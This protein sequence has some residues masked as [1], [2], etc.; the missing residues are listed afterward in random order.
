MLFYCRNDRVPTSIEALARGVAVAG[1]VARITRTGAFVDFGSEAQGLVTPDHYPAEPL[2]T[3]QQVAARVGYVDARRGR[4]RLSLRPTTDTFEEGSNVTGKVVSTVPD[5]GVFVDIGTT[6]DAL[7]PTRSLPPTD[8]VT[9][10]Q[11][12]TTWITTIDTSRQRVMLSMR[13]PF[14]QVPRG[15][16]ITGTVRQVTDQYIYVDIGASINGR[17]PTT[18]ET[19][20]PHATQVGQRLPVE[21]AEV[22]TKG[23]TITLRRQPPTA[24]ASRPTAAPPP[25]PPAHANAPPPTAPPTTDASSPAD[26]RPAPDELNASAPRKIARLMATTPP[27]LPQPDPSPVATPA[28]CLDQASG[29]RAGPD[30][31][32]HTT[33]PTDTEAPATAIAPTVTQETPTTDDPDP[34]TLPPLRPPRTRPAL[35]TS[36]PLPPPTATTIPP[37]LLLPAP[38]PRMTPPT[39]F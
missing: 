14:A 17:L 22:D 11:L 35:P 38:R 33:P 4:V 28:G 3:G 37:T 36:L 21:V 23:R 9:P 12:V 34:E 32:A 24:T 26:G 10:G 15:A 39:P 7:V 27:L 13:R 5:V 20:D 25:P 1:T 18:P 31:T 30:L 2:Y 8:D 6:T 16:S 19:T 29:T